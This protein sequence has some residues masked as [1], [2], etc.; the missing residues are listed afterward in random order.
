MEF[1]QKVP[2]KL[3]YY[4]IDMLYWYVVYVK[5]DIFSIPSIAEPRYAQR[6]KN[7]EKNEQLLYLPIIFRLS[8]KKRINHKIQTQSYI[9][10]ISIYF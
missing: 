1:L 5:Y 9:M 8:K 10:Y 4:Y 6:C 3:L 7:L 2:R